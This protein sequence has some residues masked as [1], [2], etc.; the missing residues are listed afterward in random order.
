MMFVFDDGDGDMRSVLESV[1]SRSMV[2]L[3]HRPA[4]HTAVGF[5]PAAKPRILRK[6]QFA[7]SNRRLSPQ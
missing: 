3:G 4:H 1:C 6:A 7:I 5:I 2:L